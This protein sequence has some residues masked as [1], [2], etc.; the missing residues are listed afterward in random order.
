MA[1]LKR[2]QTCSMWN[3]AHNGNFARHPLPLPAPPRLVPRTLRRRHTI[4]QYERDAVTIQDP[5]AASNRHTKTPADRPAQHRAALRFTLALA[6]LDLGLC[7][8]RPIT[9]TAATGSLRLR[10]HAAKCR[11]IAAAPW[12]ALVLSPMPLFW[13]APPE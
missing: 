4:Q 11:Q 9:Q 13:L 6:S 5:R 2:A 7:L 3:T 8:G 1:P 10:Q 12:G